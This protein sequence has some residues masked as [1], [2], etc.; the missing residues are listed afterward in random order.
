MTERLPDQ[1][2]QMEKRFLVSQLDQSNFSHM[3]NL[4][5]NQQEKQ[6]I[7]SLLLAHTSIFNPSPG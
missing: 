2:K 3:P 1:N 7:E 6:E 4:A 5:G